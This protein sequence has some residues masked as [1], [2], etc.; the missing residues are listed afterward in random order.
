MKCGVKLLFWKLSKVQNLHP[1]SSYKNSFIFEP[2]KLLD[3]K[4]MMWQGVLLIH[5]VATLLHSQVFVNFSLNFQS[6]DR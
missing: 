6:V 1:Y 2:T 4:A 3:F 5:W